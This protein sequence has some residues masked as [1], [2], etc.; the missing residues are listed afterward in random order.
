ML[1]SGG[2]DGAECGASPVDCFKGEATDVSSRILMSVQSSVYYITP[3]DVQYQS[4]IFQLWEKRSS[5]G[6]D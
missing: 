4:L 1:N 6:E 2:S 5:G 3:T